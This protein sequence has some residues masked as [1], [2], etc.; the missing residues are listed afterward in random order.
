MSSTTLTDAFGYPAAG[1]YHGND[2]T[3]CQNPLGFDAL[4]GNTNYKLACGMTG[5][6]SGGPWLS[7]F[8][9]TGNAGTIRSLNSYGYS[10]QSNNMYGPIFNA[11]TTATYNAANSTSTQSNTI[12]H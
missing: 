7:G 3:Y 2:L 4:T 11:D 10:G 9:S 5:G 12:V 6:S 8:D 1:R